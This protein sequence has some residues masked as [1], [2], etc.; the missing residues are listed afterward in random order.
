MSTSSSNRAAM[1]GHTIAARC[2]RPSHMCDD[3]TA[4]ARRRHG[5]AL[6]ALVVGVSVL[7]TTCH[8]CAAA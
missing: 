3:P 4:R 6:V 7:T 8:E 1:E 2:D 5:P